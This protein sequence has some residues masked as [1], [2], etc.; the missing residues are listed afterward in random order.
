MITLCRKLLPG[1][2][3]LAGERGVKRP[4]GLVALLCADAFPVNIVVSRELSS[5]LLSPNL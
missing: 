5:L 3:E 1:S 4:D 2:I